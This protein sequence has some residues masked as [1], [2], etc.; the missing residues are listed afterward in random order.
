[1]ARVAIVGKAENVQPLI[2]IISRA[3]QSASSFDSAKT[4]F[5]SPDFQQGKV[6]RI[7]ISFDVPDGDLNQILEAAATRD[8]VV[9]VTVINPASDAQRKALYKVLKG[10]S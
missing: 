9:P 3:D 5:E 2:G 4:L 10:G 1:M 7:V 6:A 8:P